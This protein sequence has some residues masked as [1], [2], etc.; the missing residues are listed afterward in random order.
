MNGLPQA[1]SSTAAT[2]T[3]ETAERTAVSDVIAEDLEAAFE[4][5][6]RL[7]ADLHGAKILLTGATGFVGTHLLESVR[8]ARACGVVDVRVVALVRN[9][10]ALHRRLP[11]TATAEWLE[12][13]VGDVSTFAQPA[14][15]LDFVIHSAN[16]APA[17]FVRS[18]GGVLSRTVREGTRHVAAVGVA[19]GAKRI[20]QLS[21][22]SVYGAHYVPSTP[23]AEEDAGQ[24][25]GD[26]P[27][28]VLARAKREADEELAGRG[29]A[30]SA[31]IARGFA[32][33]GPW[34]PLDQDFAFG[35][36]LRDG[37]A[38]QPI[39][40]AGDGRPVRSYLYSSDIV[41]WLWTLLLRGA[42][43]RVYNVG[44]EHAVSIGELAERMAVY[45]DVEV[46]GPTRATDGAPA[47]WHV[48]STLRARTEL[49]LTET[50]TLDDAI[51]RTARWWRA[52][53]S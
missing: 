21:S 49:G 2:D 12:L 36:F 43:G 32:F 41:V 20:L 18:D 5:T 34:L 40:V 29:A 7:W 4:I 50:V 37:L 52:R 46:R 3:A 53:K 35:N 30:P 47:H 45:F 38:G 26:S 9:A 14:G 28:S 25:A 22:G 44:S 1:F 31:I 48:P 15:T 51:A 27:A 10:E 24:P 17:S 33:C 16:T 23:I 42:P 13:V 8:T 19:A 11:W 39:Q 6:R